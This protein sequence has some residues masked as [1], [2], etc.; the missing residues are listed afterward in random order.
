MDERIKEVINLKSDIIL[1][2]LE[3]EGLI[4][5]L[6]TKQSFWLNDPACCILRLIKESTD[7]IP[8]SSV[9]SL[10]SARYENIDIENVSED[11]DRF[12]VDLKRHNL[13]S[14]QIQK[15]CVSITTKPNAKKITYTRPIMEVEGE[16]FHKIGAVVTGRVSSAVRQARRS[17]QRAY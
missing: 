17:G 15:E 12:I 6:E 5:D 3:D 1:S 10:V 13:L 4:V 7:G 11:I 9:M 8:L 14:S 2:T 16:H